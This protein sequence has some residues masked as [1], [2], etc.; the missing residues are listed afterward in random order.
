[1]S[2]GAWFEARL[3]L[4]PHH[5]EGG[6]APDTVIHPTT[7][8]LRCSPRPAKSLEGCFGKGWA[9]GGA[10]FE[11]RLRLAPRH[12]EGGCAPDTVMHPTTLILRCSPRPA[13]SL[14]GC[15]GKG[16]ASAGAWFEARLRLAPRY[17]EGGCAP[18]TV[19]QPTTLILRCS[20]RRR[21]ASKDDPEGA[22]HGHDALRFSSMSFRMSGVRM[23]CMA[24]SS[25]PPGMTTELARLMKL[26]GSIERR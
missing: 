24:R 9:S 25:F 16:W 21:R 15:F 7:L 8:I 22:K 17:E 26:C 10:W 5:E 6:C 12:K 19:M 23:S 13:K 11:A 3:R 4:A 18:D 1:M 20:P 14:E 2:A